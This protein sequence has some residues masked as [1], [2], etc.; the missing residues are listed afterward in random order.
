MTA[1][2][3]YADP[4]LRAKLA[5]LV[6]D[7]LDQGFLT[8]EN[9]KIISAKSILNLT[10]EEIAPVTKHITSDTQLTQEQF[11]GIYTR[12]LENRLFRWMEN[13]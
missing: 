1:F 8:F 3:L 12:N 7:T 13:I 6:F 10:E 2:L 4:F 5:F 11:V 9:F